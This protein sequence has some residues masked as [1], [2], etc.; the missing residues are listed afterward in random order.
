V[1]VQMPNMGLYR[2]NFVTT[3]KL[4]RINSEPGD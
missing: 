1:T 2:V 4:A 3:E